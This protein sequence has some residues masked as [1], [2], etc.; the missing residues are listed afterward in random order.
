[1]KRGSFYPRSCD[2]HFLTH[3]AY[4]M[5]TAGEEASTTSVHVDITSTTAVGVDEISS[6]AE[7]VKKLSCEWRNLTVKCH[8][9]ANNCEKTILDNLNGVAE[10]GK[11]TVIMGPSGAGKTTLLNTLARR[12]KD[13]DGSLLINGRKPHGADR[14]LTAYV[15]Q[16]QLIFP[17]LT[18]HEY[19]TLSAFLRMG[20]D[21]PDEERNARVE[22]VMK[23]L[24]IQNCRDTLIGGAFARVTGLSG[25]ER[26]RTQFAAEVL[27][28]PALIFCDEPTSGLDSSMAES[29]VRQMLELASDG[30]QQRTVVATIH[31]PSSQVFSLF[32]QLIVL[33]AGK[34]AFCGEAKNVLEHFSDLGY[35]CKANF[36][37]ADHFMEVLSSRSDNQEVVKAITD[38][39]AAKATPDSEEATDP[40]VSSNDDDGDNLANISNYKSSF[41]TQFTMLLWR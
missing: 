22:K 33:A 8:D 40:S 26:K 34:T 29:I 11:L 38:S 4:R 14:K 28:D 1:M 24:E 23:T 7:K 27:T 17:L 41:W 25:G 15:E 39:Y 16:E 32:D 2:T 21:V 19:L 6:T 12:N 37:P 9:V 31:Q 3:T 30:V 35:P 20:A 18:V 5:C 36:N 10:P 13:Y